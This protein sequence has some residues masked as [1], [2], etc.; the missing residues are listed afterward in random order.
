VRASLYPPAP[1]AGRIR[2][3]ILAAALLSVAAACSTPAPPPK[4]VA[5]VVE[6][7][8]P[9]TAL[10]LLLREK[11]A[12]QLTAA[13][14]DS[15]HGIS[16]ELEARNAPLAKELA[17][18]EK[19]TPDSGATETPPPASRG[20]RMGGG[21][22]GRMGGGRRGGMGGGGPGSGQRSRPATGQASGVAQGDRATAL[23]ARMTANH[24]AALE[25]VLELLDPTQ[26][27]RALKLLDDND[28]ELPA[29]AA[30]ETQ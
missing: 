28:F 11:Q 3:K 29:T 20:G 27:E 30:E 24:A 17:P 6:P 13:Q 10:A 21:R 7:A 19:T 22:G 14:E 18:L 8:P 16:A 12:L 9:A 4:T 25:R 5:D 2:V 15:I 1:P 26:R 23:R